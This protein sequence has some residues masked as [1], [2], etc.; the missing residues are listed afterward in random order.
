MNTDIGGKERVCP[1]AGHFR[2]A[3]AFGAVAL[4]CASFAGCTGEYYRKSADND[5]YKILAQKRKRA[6]N[7]ETP[8]TIQQPFGD[9][10]AGLPKRRQFLIPPKAGDPA[11]SDPAHV[12]TI[13]SLRNA[14]EIG[15]RNSRAYQT[16]KES[17]YLAALS[18]TLE[19]HLWSPIFTQ[20]MSGNVVSSNGEETWV[21]ANQFGATQLL[22]TGADLTLNL[23]TAFLRFITGNNPSPLSQSALTGTLIQP[24]WQGA[25]REI[26]Q[27]NLTLAERNVIYAV[28]SFARYHRTFVVSVATSYYSVLEQRQV[29]RNEWNNYQTL[30]EERQETE[31]LAQAGRLP[32][33]QVDQARQDELSA[34][35]S[36][37]QADEQYK[38][39]LDQLKLSLSVPTDSPLDV[40]DA[41]LA[42]L[43]ER[44]IIDPNVSAEAAVRQALALRLDLMNAQ[45]AVADAALQVKVA[46][47]G[48][49]P[50][51]NLVFAGAA[52]SAPTRMGQFNFM[53]GTYSA[54]LN[55]GL[56]LDE[57]SQRNVL[58]SSLI[59]LD[60]A[61]RAADD[62]TDNIKL[63]VRSDWITMQEAKQSYEI[64]RKSVELA[65]RRVET[66]M[67][68]LQAGRAITRDLLEAQTAWHD[69]QNALVT[70]LVN[71]TNARLALWRDVETLSV[72]PQGGI[73]E[74]AVHGQSAN[75]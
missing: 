6:L 63:Q 5:V 13:V 52:G 58:R 32:E 11:W 15:I 47:N 51:V 28:R 10:L 22:A 60:Q 45:D 24:L 16:Q 69:A 42:A 72:D 30:T 73:E 35:D 39:L 18:L 37:N 41:E 61:E 23:S 59:A 36:W 26:A 8:F 19:R 29:V 27:A 70:A 68:L 33:L 31:M 44:G 3:L 75:E 64:Q 4:A 7:E 21:G 54:G 65:E 1:R 71:H 34:H 2:R 12:L 67:I 46:N 48:L 20:M 74:K 14:I 17:V 43:S 49:A 56:P 62:L 57:T 53:Q 66:T 25:G 55:V 40:D 38:L 50:V 9:P